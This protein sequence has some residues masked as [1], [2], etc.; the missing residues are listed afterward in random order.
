[1]SSYIAYGIVGIIIVAIAWFGISLIMD[2]Q[3]VEERLAQQGDTI[4]VHYRGTL[5]NG[6]EFDSSYKRGEPFSF[7]LGAGQVIKGWDEGLVGMK[8]GEKKKLTIPP[9]KGYG[10]N[11]MPPVIP[12]NATLI[13]EVEVVGI[14]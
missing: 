10:V 4:A 9:E 14:K 8:V 1:M 3:H 2:T 5:E 11:G 6:T 12:P 13:F 7:T